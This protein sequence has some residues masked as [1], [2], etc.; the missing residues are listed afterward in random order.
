[1]SNLN[2][3]YRNLLENDYEISCKQYLKTLLN[4]IV[5]GVVFS[6][7]PTRRLYEQ[8]YSANCQAKAI[9][10]YKNNS[11]DF[12]TVFEVAKI[13]RNQIL[14][15]RNCSSPNTKTLKF[16]VIKH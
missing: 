6:R 7:P 16:F 2:K 4:G 15:H 10:T 13:I 9:E 8:L 5:P 11:D 12:A 3:T 1:M 14:K